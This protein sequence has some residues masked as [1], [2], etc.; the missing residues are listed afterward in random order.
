[1]V[2]AEQLTQFTIDYPFVNRLCAGGDGGGVEHYPDFYAE[3]AGRARVA[4]GQISPAVATSQLA[5][6]LTQLPLTMLA[7]A[8]VLAVSL[9]GLLVGKRRP[10]VAPVGSRC[11]GHFSSESGVA[12]QALRF[13]T[14]QARIAAAWPTHSQYLSFAP[15]NSRKTQTVSSQLETSARHYAGT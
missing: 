14:A 12:R 5:T 8:G 2:A 15:E 3:R 6:D 7:A 9:L 4:V 13:C 10:A 1:M 11:Q